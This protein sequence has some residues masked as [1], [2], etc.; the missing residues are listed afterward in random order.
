MIGEIMD[1]QGKSITAGRLR[2]PGMALT[3]HRPG[4]PSC[5]VKNPLLCLLLCLLPGTGMFSAL[6]AQDNTLY[7][8]HAVPQSIDL[9]PAIQYGCRMFVELPVLS[10]IGVSLNSTGAGYHDLIH[11]GTGSQSDSLYYDF[12][13]LQKKLRKLNALKADLDLTLLGFGFARDDWYF[14]FRIASHTQLRA[15]IPSDI[16][17]LKDGNWNTS[18]NVPLNI[19][20]TGMG[21]NAISYFSIA[22]TASKCVDDNLQW[23]VRVKYLMGAANGNTGSS[24]LKLITTNNPITLDA[25]SKVKLN[26][27][28]PVDIAYDAQGYATSAN[29]SRAGKN[30]VHNYIFNGNQGLGVDLGVVYRYDDNIT[31]Y[32]SAIDLGFIWWRSNINRFTADGS[33]VF[34]GIDLAG[35]NNGQQTQLLNALNDSISNALRLSNSRHS[36]VTLLSSKIFGGATYRISPVLS[37][38]LLAKSEIYDWGLHP[39]LTASLNYTPFRFLSLSVSNSYMNN[40]V[41]NLGMAIAVGGRIAQFYLVS[42]NIPLRYVKDKAT[43]MVWPYNARSVSLRF[44]INLLFGCNDKGRKI[45]SLGS[46]SCPAYDRPVVIR[47]M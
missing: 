7:F 41:D 43:G 17:A 1:G 21:A 36:Y 30:I 44:G 33:F 3:V 23:G 6:Q 42:D 28:F 32:A 35:L 4:I 37:A 29:F 14:S 19:N 27:S 11:Y 40:V 13:G 10:S 34:K 8:L 12:N 9:N 15:E 31:F 5:R 16:L 25:V 46:A 24:Q 45:H 18:A 26:A 2:E 39:S 47:K 38:G 22:A 20:L